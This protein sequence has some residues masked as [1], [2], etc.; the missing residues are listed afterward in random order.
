MSGESGAENRKEAEERLLELAAREELFEQ[1]INGGERLGGGPRGDRRRERANVVLHQPGL[2]GARNH[3]H[4]VP[5]ERVLDRREE[6]GSAADI[7]HGSEDR[8]LRGLLRGAPQNPT[9]MR[10]RAE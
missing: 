8:G 10:S 1:R 2:L 6:R 3:A 5:Y 7:A 4:H 9:I